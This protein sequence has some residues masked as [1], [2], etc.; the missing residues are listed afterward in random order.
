MTGLS[1]NVAEMSRPMRSFLN[2][3]D[4]HDVRCLICGSVMLYRRTFGNIMLY[5]AAGLLYRRRRKQRS[6]RMMMMICGKAMVIR[7][8]DMVIWFK[9]GLSPILLT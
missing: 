7:G 3:N 8:K 9:S 4:T 2:E 5:L 1:T 6:R